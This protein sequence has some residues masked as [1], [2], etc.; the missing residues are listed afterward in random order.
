MNDLFGEYGEIEGQSDCRDSRDVGIK[1]AL[2][3]EYVVRI[4]SSMILFNS[5]Q[6]I[7]KFMR[8]INMARI[9]TANI[10]IF[11]L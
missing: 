1:E 5:H 3:Y 2:A 10:Y 11:D 7:S 4:M 9:L 8:K 6:T